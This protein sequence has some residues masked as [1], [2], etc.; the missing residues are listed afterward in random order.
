MAKNNS[1]YNSYNPATQLLPHVQKVEEYLEK[2]KS[3]PRRFGFLMKRLLLVLAVILLMTILI[4]RYLLYIDFQNRCYILIKPSLL[5]FSSR[6]IQ[7][8]IRVLKYAVPIEYQKLCQY[9]DTINPNIS[10]GGFEGG[11]YSAYEAHPGEIDVGTAHEQFLGWTAAV[12]AHETCHSQQFQEG[13]PFDE[14]ECYE[15][16][17]YVLKTVVEF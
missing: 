13:R 14:K 7:E 6:N 11:C 1:S 16:D 3:R 8:G 17:N 12:I 10:C 9:V 2:K 4:Y 15:I 5:E